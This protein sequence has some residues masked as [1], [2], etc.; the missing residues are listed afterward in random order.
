MLDASQNVQPNIYKLEKDFVKT[1]AGHF[2]LSPSGPR[3]SA[4]IYGQDAF[5]VSRFTDSNFESNVD[6]A[7]LLGKTR[8]MDIALEHSARIFSS[9]RKG[10]R[11]IAILLTTGNSAAGSKALGEAVT[12]LRRTGAQVFI[13]LIGV[14]V[15]NRQAFLAVDRLKDI[16]M[17]Q[18]AEDLLKRSLPIA[19][20]I[21]GKPG[22][23]L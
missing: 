19:L 4:V 6:G 16:F 3:G 9:S 23:L 15:N 20:I 8:R 2:N 5:T 13:V 14:K 21:R 17:D 22:E 10:S 7:N 11:K 12:P 1:M 18:R